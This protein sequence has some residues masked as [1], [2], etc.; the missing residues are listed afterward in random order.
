MV[1]SASPQEVAITPEGYV[2][3]S[4]PYCRTSR[5]ASVARYRDL[6]APVTVE[7]E[8]EQ[9]FDILVD[10]RQFYRQ[11]LHLPGTYIPLESTTPHQLIVKTLSASGVSFHTLSAAPLQVDDEVTLWFQLD[12]IWQTT[13]RLRAVVHWVQDAMV[14]AEFCDGHLHAQDLYDYLRLTSGRGKPRRGARKVWRDGPP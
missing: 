4:C 13:L 9:L 1:L 8:C 11:R 2:A 14:G 3:F 10:T 12:D 5:T 6:H 7:C